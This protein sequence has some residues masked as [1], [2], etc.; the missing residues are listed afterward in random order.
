MSSLGGGGVP[1]LLVSSPS[2]ALPTIVAF[3]IPGVILVLV[4]A[5]LVVA[6]HVVVE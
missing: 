2:S 1:P 4:I 6:T 5:I 3:A